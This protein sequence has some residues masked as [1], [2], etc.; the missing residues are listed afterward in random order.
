MTSIGSIKSTLLEKRGVIHAFGFRQFSL[1]DYLIDL[2]MPSAKFFRTNQMHGD[3]IVV[4]TSDTAKEDV[5]EA[6]AF[7][8]N[9]KGIVAYI[10]TADCVPVLL[11]DPVKGVVASVHAGWRGTSKRIV[12]KTVALMTNEFGAKPA[13]ICAAI[14]PAI[15]LN[16]YEVDERVVKELGTVGKET[17]SGKYFV[18]LKEINRSQLINAGVSSIDKLDICNHCDNRFASFR[19]DSG[20]SARQVSFII[21]P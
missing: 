3:N 8:T 13:N 20:D 2:E 4:L 7:V 5:L 16:C 11:C 12:E 21:T 6:D 10:R 1:M 17:A 9:E 19:R 18:D 15:G 14:G